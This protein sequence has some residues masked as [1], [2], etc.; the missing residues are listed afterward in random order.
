MVGALQSVAGAGFIA[1]FVPWADQVLHIGTSGWRFG[2]VFAV[3]GVGGRRGVGADAVAAAPVPRRPHDAWA[4]SPCRR[5]AGLAAALAPNWVLASVGMV[6]WGVAYQLVLIT[7]ITYRMQVTPEHLLG[8]VNTAGRMLSWGLGWTLGS[9]AGGRARRRRSR[10]VPA[11]VGLVCVGFVAAAYAWLSP[12]RQIAAED[13][14]TRAGTP[15]LTEQ[16]DQARR[17]RPA[18]RR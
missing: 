14:A 1:L 7:S 12:L 10:S 9:V 2:L 8:R 5:V 4:P 18:R 11:M 13:A 3:W 17:R 6:V 15:G 16:P